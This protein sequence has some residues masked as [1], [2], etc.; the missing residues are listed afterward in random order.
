[1]DIVDIRDIV[2][3]VDIGIRSLIGAIMILGMDIL[4]PCLH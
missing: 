4:S 2:D 3:N 1:M